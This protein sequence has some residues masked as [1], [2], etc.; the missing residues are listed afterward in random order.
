MNM[1]S[2]CQSELYCYVQCLDCTNLVEVVQCPPPHGPICLPLQHRPMSFMINFTATRIDI[3]LGELP[4]AFVLPE[5]CDSVEE[6]DHEGGEV[7]LEEGSSVH[8][9]DCGVELRREC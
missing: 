3:D 5:E 7:A 9:L 2:D 1:H 6:N 8:W 4:E